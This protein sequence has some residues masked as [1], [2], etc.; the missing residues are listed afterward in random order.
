MNLN[1]DCLQ[2][3]AILLL[4]LLSAHLVSA[5]GTLTVLNTGGGQPLISAVRPLFVDGVLVQPR[6]LFNLGFA[7]DETGV[8]GSFLDSFTVTIQDLNQ[9]FTAIYLTVDAAGTVVAPP[10]PGTVVIDSATISTDAMAYPSLNPVL[11]NR[12]A[13][14]VS[15]PI[16]VQFIGSQINIYFDLFD[17]L[18]PIPSQGWFSDLTLQSVPEP[19][20][21]TLLALGGALRLLR[22]RKRTP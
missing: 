2:R 21:W 17:N 20:T 18:N 5:Q 4:L 1:L 8:P 13:Y 14:A 11:L 15:A 7:T 16:P 9:V 19:A 22:R 6:L 12:R 3:R 10:T